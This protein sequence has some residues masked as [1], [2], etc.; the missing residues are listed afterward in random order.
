MLKIKL[1]VI[2]STILVFNLFEESLCARGGGAKTSRRRTNKFCAGGSGG[3]G[4]GL[5]GSIDC[6]YFLKI[7]NIENKI[8]V[9]GKFA[10]SKQT[11]KNQICPNAQGS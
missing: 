6:K 9:I 3:G 8:H 2:L 10:P 1:Y 7:Y 4:R 11:I 5:S